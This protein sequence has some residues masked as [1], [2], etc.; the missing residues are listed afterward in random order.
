MDLKKALDSF[1]REVCYNILNEFDET[2]KANN[3]TVSK[4]KL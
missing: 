2:S 4:R 1:R 3:S